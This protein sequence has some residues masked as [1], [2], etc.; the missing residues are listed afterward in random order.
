MI[1]GTPPRN[2]APR[3][4]GTVT[5]QWV[6]VGLA[7]V[8]VV[9]VLFWFGRDWGGQPIH[10]GGGGHGA[11]AEVPAVVSGTVSTWPSSTPT[12]GR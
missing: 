4:R 2:A 6:G 1:C 9:G 11:P 12:S 5:L 8:A 7:V 3:Q 10:G